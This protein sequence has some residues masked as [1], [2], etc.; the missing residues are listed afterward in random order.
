[1]AYLFFA[2]LSFFLSSV[3]GRQFFALSLSFI[4][5]QRLKISSKPHKLSGK[6]HKTSF[7]GIGHRTNKS[8]LYMP[9]FLQFV[10]GYTSN[11]SKYEC[12]FLDFLVFNDGKKV[13]PRYDDAS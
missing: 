4:K 1:V 10:L 5:H 6:E 12:Y 13:V 11:Y 9:L 3:N 2:L 7:P 8:A